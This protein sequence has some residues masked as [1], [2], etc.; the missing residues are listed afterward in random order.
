MNKCHTV[1]KFQEKEKENSR[2]LADFSHKNQNCG[3]VPLHF[4]LIKKSLK[5][6]TMLSVLLCVGYEFLALS[7]RSWF[8][9]TNIHP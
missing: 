3:K 1:T 8:L 5:I 7:E 2:F 9:G 6:A 4:K